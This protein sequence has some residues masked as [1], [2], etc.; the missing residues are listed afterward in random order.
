M[1]RPDR[2]L[3]PVLGLFPGLACSLFAGEIVLQNGLNDYQGASDAALYGQH[4]VQQSRNYGQ[5]ATLKVAG[6][7]HGGMKNLALIRFGDL[8][9]PGALPAGAQVRQAT[10]RLYKVG[11]PEDRGQYEKAAPGQRVI[12]AT[13]LL[14]PWVAGT[15]NGEPEEGSVTFACR[16]FQEEIPTFWGKAN[17]VEN[18]PVKGIDFEEESAVSCRLTPGEESVWMEWDITA[19]VREWVADP[20]TNHGLLLSARSFYIG[21]YFASCEAE[22]AFRPQLEISFN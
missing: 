7:A 3:F 14:T 6:V 12:R 13:R 1:L 9:A 18:G 8:T 11:E 15:K 10:L 19:F 22:E 5:A 17:R 16:A 2:L 20:A 21:S 4:E